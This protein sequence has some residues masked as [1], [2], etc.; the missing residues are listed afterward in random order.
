M[1][2]IYLALI[3]LILLS[4][5]WFVGYTYLLGFDVVISSLF[6]DTLLIAIVYFIVIALNSIKLY[7]K[8]GIKLVEEFFRERKKYQEKYYKNIKSK[9]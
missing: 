7:R 5:I 3:S 2:K 4:M 6:R 8:S 9:D 1:K